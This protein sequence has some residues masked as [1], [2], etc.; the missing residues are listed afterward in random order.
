[1]LNFGIAQALG[2]SSLE[3]RDLVALS[4]THVNFLNHNLFRLFVDLFN[5]YSVLTLFHLVVIRVELVD[6]YNLL[7]Y[8]VS[9]G[10]HTALGLGPLDLQLGFELLGLLPVL[11]YDLHF[12]LDLF[13][14]FLHDFI[15]LH[16]IPEILVA[17]F[18]ISLQFFRR[19]V[20]FFRIDLVVCIKLVGLFTATADL[21]RTA[22]I[23][24]H[25]H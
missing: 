15:S 7:G 20:G 16:E 6:R 10:L 9:T 13:H 24:V 14:V 23:L 3:S 21:R 12:L 1:M 25:F 22:F 5:F 11:F 19:F 4:K 18:V 8:V 2:D 17:R